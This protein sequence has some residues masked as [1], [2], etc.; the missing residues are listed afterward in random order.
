MSEKMITGMS[1]QDSIASMNFGS[2]DSNGNITPEKSLELIIGNLAGYKV[3]SERAVQVNYVMGDD[4]PHS[5]NRGIS[6]T[7][8]LL[9]FNT[10]DVDFETNF[11]KVINAIIKKQKEGNADETLLRYAKFASKILI[12]VN[13]KRSTKVNYLTPDLVTLSVIPTFDFILTDKKGNREVIKGCKIF[14]FDTGAGTSTVGA[15]TTYRFSA[16]RIIPLK[17]ANG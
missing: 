10:Y 16:K 6:K 5:V 8:G 15:S 9:A 4:A 17:K 2:Y 14:A 12:N 11:C 3:D 1:G 7:E 13:K